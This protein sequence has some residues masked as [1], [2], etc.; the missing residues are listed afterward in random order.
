MAEV[1]QILSAISDGDPQAAEEL[2]PLVYE[3][4]RRLA[5]QKMSREKVDHT[6]QPTALVHEVFLRL[7]GASPIDWESRAHFFAAAAKAM[8]RILIDE[9]RRKKRLKR[10][11]DRCRIDL[12]NVDLAATA[13]SDELIALD[14]ALAKLETEDPTKAELVRLR[15][16]AGLTL[17]QVAEIL[18]ISR[19][20]ASRYWTYARAWLYHEIMAA[21]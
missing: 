16:F 7:V 8:R 19:A 5:E 13:S 4:L 21:K 6:L 18:Q 12:D 14:E 15:Y 20:T 3:E 2:L 1:T 9:A 17:E 10:G 11:G